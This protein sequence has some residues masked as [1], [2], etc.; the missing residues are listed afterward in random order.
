MTMSGRRRSRRRASVCL[1]NLAKG[2]TACK[3]EDDDDVDLTKMAFDTKTG[4]IKPLG[5]S[6]VTNSALAAFIT[7]FAAPQCSRR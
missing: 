3:P 2:V 5:P 6:R 1:E 4:E 7:G